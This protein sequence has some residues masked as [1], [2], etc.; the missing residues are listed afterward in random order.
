MRLQ[1]N[2]FGLHT[3]YVLNCYLYILQCHSRKSTLRARKYTAIKLEIVIKYTLL[4]KKINWKYPR[5]Q[6]SSDTRYT[7]R[8]HDGIFLIEKFSTISVDFIRTGSF[9]DAIQRNICASH[10]R[11]EAS[12]LGLTMYNVH[13][14]ISTSMCLRAFTWISSSFRL[15]WYFSSLYFFCC[16][17]NNNALCKRTK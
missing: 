11:F 10:F 8:F 13:V 17:N 6:Q 14:S 2:Y 15:L 1:P 7:F 16:S 5:T 3:R 4:K 9:C 12:L